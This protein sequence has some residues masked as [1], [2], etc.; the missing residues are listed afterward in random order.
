MYKQGRDRL[1][2]PAPVLKQMVTAGLRGRKTGRGFYT[3]EA[4][5][6]PVVVAD[7]LTPVEPADGDGDRHAHGAQ[8]RRRRLRHDGHR[9]RRGLREGGLRRP[10]RHPRRRPGRAGARVA[11]AL[12]RQGACCAA[13][14]PRTTATPPW[15]ASTGSSRL[16]DLADVRPRRRGRRRGALG[17]GRAVRDARRDLQAGR[18]PRDHDVEPAGGRPRRRHEAPGRRRRAALLQPRAGHEAGR[19]GLHRRHRRRRRRHGGRGVPDAWASTRSRAATA[20]ASSST[21]CCSPTST[22]P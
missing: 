10:V 4:P 20:P 6:S 2:A 16:D 21:R 12:A 14:S 3:Y 1:H 17:Q 22:T 8:R 18:D 13:S 15:P 19:G 9:H 5:N 11:R 7:A